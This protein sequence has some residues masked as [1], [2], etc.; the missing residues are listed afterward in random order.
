MRF[1]RLPLPMSV[2]R[3]V[4]NARNRVFDLGDAVIP[5]GVALFDL[6][7]GLQRD[8]DRGRAGLV[9]VGRCPR[10]GFA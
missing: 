7:F 4:T 10:Q 3:G 6:V 9:R 8:E 2:A 5:G 1:P